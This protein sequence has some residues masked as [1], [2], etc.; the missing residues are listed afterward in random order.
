VSIVIRKASDSDVDVVA[1]LVHALLSEL[2]PAGLTP[3]TVEA[4][5]GATMQLLNKERGVWA[6]LAEDEHSAT[7]GVLTLH[8]CAAIYAGGR[9]GEISE[10]FVKP[11]ARSDGVGPALLK[12]AIRFGHAMA[13]QRLE[14]GAPEVP[15]WNRSVSFY[16]RNGFLETG[17]RLRLPL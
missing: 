13:W 17:P 14:V 2:T 7:V 9:F 15:Q 8:E 12:E 10:L 4:V 6:F 1:V 11:A 5:R 16:L 3:P